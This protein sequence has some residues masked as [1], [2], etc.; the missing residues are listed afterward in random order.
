MG[1]GD[2]ESTGASIT[3]RFCVL[4]ALDVSAAALAQMEGTTSLQGRQSASWGDV[5]ASWTY[6]P[7]NGLDMILTER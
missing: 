6:H 7:D 5:D 1:K 2:E 4:E 3:D